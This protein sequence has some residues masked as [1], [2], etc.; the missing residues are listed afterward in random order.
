MPSSVVVGAKQGSSLYCHQF[1]LSRDVFILVTLGVK[2]LHERVLCQFWELDIEFLIALSLLIKKEQ[3]EE[4]TSEPWYTSYGKASNNVEAVSQNDLPQ[5]ILDIFLPDGIL[6]AK[7]SSALQWV[8]L[9][10][11]GHMVKVYFL[12]SQLWK[13]ICGGGGLEL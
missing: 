8:P 7:P 10:N 2:F 5:E 9:T 3:F 13:I 1:I 6:L 11:V 4:N 12:L